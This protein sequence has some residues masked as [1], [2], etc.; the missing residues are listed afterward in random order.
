MSELFGTASDFGP[1]GI[2]SLAEAQQSYA[3]SGE[4]TA[5]QQAEQTIANVLA[6]VGDRSN[7][8]GSTNYD[9]IFAQAFNMAR[10]LQPGNRVAGDYFGADKF[11]NQSDLARPSYLQ[12]QVRGDK[13]MYFSQGERFLQET[14]PPI[15][16]GIR[17]ISPTGIITNLINR[18][19]D[20]YD[21]GKEVYDETF[22]D[23]IFRRYGYDNEQ[24]QKVRKQ[25][26]S[27]APTVEPEAYDMFGNR[28]SELTGQRGI[29]IGNEAM[30]QQIDRSL[31]QSAL[32]AI[33]DLD[34][35]NYSSLSST[36]APEPEKETDVGIMQNMDRSE[37]TDAGRA[38]LAGM[39]NNNRNLPQATQTADL[40]LKNLLTSP[41]VV[42]QALGY[43]QPFIQNI[44]PEGVNYD[45]GLIFDRDKPEDSYTGI[46][47]TIPFSTG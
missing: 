16:Q 9:P 46:K 17:N 37:L 21:K 35:I 13:G 32:D 33:G 43:T 27:S 15:I 41:G 31:A 25:L 44:L 2:S 23:T 8:R 36:P 6:N 14:L 11:V 38:I 29:S 4:N 19:L 7:I 12:P 5:D 47:F 26:P 34:S 40:N 42:G 3:D 18:G 22:G 45:A 10:G 30:Q 20:V 39:Q 24:K 1:S 28:M